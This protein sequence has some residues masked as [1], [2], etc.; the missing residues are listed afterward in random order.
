MVAHRCREI[1]VIHPGALGDVLQAIPALTALRVLEEGTRLAFAG[2][3]RLAGLLSAAGVVDYAVPFDGLGL[4][5]LFA[6]DSL[7][8]SVRSR[9]SRFGRV[10]SW[11]GARAE[12]F[13]ARLRSIVPEALIGPPVPETGP[14]LTVWEHLLKTLFPWGMTGLV[15]LVP[16]SLPDAW[17][18]EARRTLTELGADG[19]QPLLV[20]HPGAGGEW[21]RW[22][23]EGFARV[24]RKVAQETGCQVLVHQGPADKDVVEELSRALALPVLH[25]LEPPLELLAAV[26]QESGAYLGGDSGVSHLAAAVGAPA[27]ILFPP[28]TRDRWAPWSP[29]AVPLAVGGDL[30][31]VETI[32][33]AVS[34][35]LS[36]ERPD[37]ASPGAGRGAG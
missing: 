7:P 26:L 15:R 23:V 11:F 30:H 9:L 32:A 3:M 22:P 8:P 34:E 20:V 17:R 35:R 36:A 14:H 25:L 29:T 6:G 16:M 12:P 21:K 31:E 27:V 5:T 33:Q 13:P 2:Q 19:S 28:A 24:I 10:I 37:P 4:E 1:L 18:T